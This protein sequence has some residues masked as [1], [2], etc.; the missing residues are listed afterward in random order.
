MDQ[1]FEAFGIDWRLLL[2]NAINF[3]VLLGGLTY[4]LYKPITKT[5][6]ER[7]QKVLKGVADAEAA[8]AA[9]MEIEGA[10]AQKLAEA[11]R[12]ADD[13]LSKAQKTGTEKGRELVSQAE[14]S[15][16]RVLAEAQAQSVELKAQAIQESKEEIAKLIILGIEKTAVN[17]K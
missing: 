15:A 9:L 10:R 8:E 4:F 2:I 1:L 7:R 13:I 11:G 16:A 12:E 6:E 3:G 17:A 14:G 5:L